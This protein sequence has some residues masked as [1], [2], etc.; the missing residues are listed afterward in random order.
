[1]VHRMTLGT[2]S[3]PSVEEGLRLQ[4]LAAFAL[5]EG[6][7]DYPWYDSRFLHK[8]RAALYLIEK[9]KPS[10]KAEFI[11]ALAPLQT[12]P[13]FRTVSI[14]RVFGD[15]V[16]E[17]IRSIVRGLRESQ[18]ER[19]EAGSF[20]RLVQDLASD[21]AGERLVPTYNFLSLYNETGVCQ[22]HLD[23]P[24]SKWTL[25]LCIDQSD[26]WP[27]HLSQVVPWPMDGSFSGEDWE[28]RVCESSDLAFD[29]WS[30]RPGQAVWFS[31]SSQWHYRKPLG[32]ARP[33]AF[34]HLL[35]FHFT[36]ASMVEH[37]DPSNWPRLFGLPELEAVV[38][39]PVDDR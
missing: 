4:L 25:D 30:M 22:P 1:M 20:G 18:F 37:V 24:Q 16:L 33:G 14:D 5:D 6:R 19:H 8:Y 9:I 21:L 39:Q 29:A 10:L 3:V 28:A 31:G 2:P 32:P 34:C 13:D 38:V 11:R 36:P 15:G 26:E 12:R 35:F 27:I 23:S 7:R 17:E